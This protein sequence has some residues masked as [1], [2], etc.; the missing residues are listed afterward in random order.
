M[1]EKED[2]VRESEQPEDP[3]ASHAKQWAFLRRT[4]SFLNWFESPKTLKIIRPYIKDGQ[5]VVDMGCGWGFYT[6]LLADLVGPEGKVYSVELSEKCIQSIQK[7]A[8]QRGY[9]HIEVH[10]SSAAD[11]G[12]INDRSVDFIF[13]N[14]LLCSMENDRPL[15]VKEMERILKP[16][17]HAYIS[18]GAQP[19]FGLV[20]EAE[21]EEILSRFK[22]VQ[23]GIYKEL[24]ALVSLKP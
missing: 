18:L 15:A 2:R 8:N 22:V 11:V 23:G 4:P 14:G 6:F 13:A 19:P 9:H 5:V 17:G 1:N 7:K 3:K 20:D 21:W 10:A 24:W 16:G 12:F